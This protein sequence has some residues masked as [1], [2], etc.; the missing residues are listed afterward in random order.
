MTAVVGDRSDDAG[1]ISRRAV[2]L[3]GGALA[4]AAGA[5]TVG[6]VG[7]S[8]VLHKFGLSESPDHRVAPNGARVR[9]FSFRSDAMGGV[10]RGGIAA[11]ANARAV[12]LCLH[13]RGASYRMAFDAVHVHH[14]VAAARKPIA[15][16]A[17]NGGESS[18]WHKRRSGIDPQAML[19]D[20]LLPRLD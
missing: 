16:V 10:V 14:V 20:E 19:H 5:A 7:W 2:L 4:V 13:G 9:P 11:P 3:G 15:V 18:Y 8:D 17:V 1:R 12:L 6:A